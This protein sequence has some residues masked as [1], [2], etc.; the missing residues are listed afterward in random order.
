MIRTQAQATKVPSTQATRTTIRQMRHVELQG[1]DASRIIQNLTAR[2]GR[3]W[4]ATTR[5]H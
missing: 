3:G 1:I 2:N 4:Q 5:T